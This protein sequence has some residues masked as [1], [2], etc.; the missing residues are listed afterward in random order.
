MSAYAERATAIQAI[1]TDLRLRME[2]A[3]VCGTI[4]DKMAVI[5][6]GVEIINKILTCFLVSQELL[7]SIDQKLNCYYTALDPSPSS[8]IRA[9]YALMSVVRDVE[10]KAAEW[11]KRYCK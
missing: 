11:V 10:V 9:F 5:D 7:D 4:A 3:S 8:V 6:L 2:V 1:A